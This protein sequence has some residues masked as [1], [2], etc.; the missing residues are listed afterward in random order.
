MTERQ[1]SCDAEAGGREPVVDMFPEAISRRL[2]LVSE[3]YE[4]GRHLA[5]AKPVSNDSAEISADEGAVGDR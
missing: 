3:L 2:D 4:L 1:N 5:Q